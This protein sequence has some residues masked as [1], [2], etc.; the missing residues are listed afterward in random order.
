MASPDAYMM[1]YEPYRGGSNPN[2]TVEN[3]SKT[4][5]YLKMN[6]LDDKVKRDF[7]ETIFQWLKMEVLVLAQTGP[8]VIAIAPGHE[9]NLNPTGFMYEIVGR[10]L[11]DTDCSASVTGCQLLRTV[12]VLKQSKTPGL[13]TEATHRETIEVTGPPN[14]AGKVVVILDDVWTSGSTLRVCKEVML[15]TLPKE[16]KLFAIGKTV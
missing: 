16:V 12:T 2:H 11:A 14:N 10:L 6:Y 8:V 5:S 3:C 1:N 7:C 9:A 13:R 4:L 15:T